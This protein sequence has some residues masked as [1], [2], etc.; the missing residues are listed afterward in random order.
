MNEVGGAIQRINDPNMVTLLWIFVIV[1]LT[2]FFTE[3]VVVGESV[4]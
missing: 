4:S 2:R 1:G 3:E